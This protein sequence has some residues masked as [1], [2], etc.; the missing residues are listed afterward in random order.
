[1]VEKYYSIILY[2]KY[3]CQLP[4]EYLWNIVLDLSLKD[5]VDILT[6]AIPYIITFLL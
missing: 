6:L 2:K 1:M 3:Y 5:T 4:M